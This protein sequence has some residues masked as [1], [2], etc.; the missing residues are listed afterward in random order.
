ME[1]VYGTL[2]FSK[3]LGWHQPY[4]GIIQDNSHGE[5]LQVPLDF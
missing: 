3:F 4:T 1:G 5:D 2:Y